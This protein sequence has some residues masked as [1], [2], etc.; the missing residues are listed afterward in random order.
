[1][2]MAHAVRRLLLPGF[3]TLAALA[4]L[5]ALG[6]WQ[7]ERKAWKE[8]LIETL[9]QRLAAPPVALPP[10]DQWAG[11]DQQQDEF[12]RVRFRAEY[13]PGNEA[14]VWATGSALRDDV[15]SPGIFVFTPARLSSG[16][17]I[18]V[19]RGFVADRKPTGATP[20]PAPASG[21]V[22]ITGVLRWPEP[23]G[24]ELTASYDKGAQL[25]FVRDHRAMANEKGWGPVAPFYIEREAQEPSDGLP[26]PGPLKASLPNNHLQYA[27]TW[28]GLALVLLSVFALWARRAF[29]VKARAS[30]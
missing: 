1:M 27:L 21:T 29:L 26:P 11:L 14:L 12:R 22:E 2:S 5:I 20:R 7:L 15:K 24:W 3:M 16:E 23:K 30:D 6:T 13:L 17:V 4:V 28:Y 8:D 10:P 25:W 18:A 19:N 9:T